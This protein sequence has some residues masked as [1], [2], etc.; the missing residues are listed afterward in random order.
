MRKLLGLGAALAL[1]VVGLPAQVAQAAEFE[2]LIEN[3]A[4]IPDTQYVNAG[5]TVTWVWGEDPAPHNVTPIPVEGQESPIEGSGDRGPGP[6]EP[7]SVDFPEEGTYPYFCTIHSSPEGTEPDD[8]NG[9]IIVLPAG[10]DPAPGAPP[11]AGT[12]RVAAGDR[13]RQCGPRLEQP[14]RRRQ[15]PRRAAGP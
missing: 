9:E 10:D 6:A 5:D 3:F 12:G 13:Q 11:R 7:Y 15:R 8:Q 14:L 4:F 1:L 2:V